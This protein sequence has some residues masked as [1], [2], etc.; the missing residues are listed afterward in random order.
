MLKS[1]AIA[2]FIVFLLLG[3]NSCRKDEVAEKVTFIDSLCGAFTG[4]CF[5]L[6]TLNVYPPCDQGYDS[7]TNISSGVFEA[8]I[9]VTEHNEDSIHIEG[10]AVGYYNLAWTF[11][12]THSLLFVENP[13]NLSSGYTEFSVQFFGVDYDSIHIHTRFYGYDPCWNNVG[14]R[15]YY[16][17]R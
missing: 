17:S 7:T 16:L 14:H 15:N 9:E 13:G 3:T 6:D 10:S 11:P 5:W 12:M 8:S 1:C 4:D 2:C